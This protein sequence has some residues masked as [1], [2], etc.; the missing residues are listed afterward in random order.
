[1][2]RTILF[3]SQF[4][5]IYCDLL[6]YPFCRT[7]ISEQSYFNLFFAFNSCRIMK[8]IYNRSHES[9]LHP[10]KLGVTFSTRIWIMTYAV[11]TV[12]FSL[13]IRSL[14]KVW[15]IW[16]VLLT[17]EEACRKCSVFITNT[18]Y[19]ISHFTPSVDI[20]FQD[21]LLKIL[22]I[23]SRSEIFLLLV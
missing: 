4:Y 23:W 2:N 19:L 6:S 17:V 10:S 12:N 16:T 20:W 3:I 1:M 22:G 9:D 8:L 15:K 11:K 7:D 5:V 21:S 18:V 13:L 14:I